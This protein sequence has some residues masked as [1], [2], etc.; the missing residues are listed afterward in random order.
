MFPSCRLNGYG[1]IRHPTLHYFQIPYIK[2][3]TKGKKNSAH[4]RANQNYDSFLNDT[5]QTFPDTI[6]CSKSIYAG[7][8]AVL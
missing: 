7:Y 6:G 8:Q 4:Y 2:E 3:D 1:V 5:N